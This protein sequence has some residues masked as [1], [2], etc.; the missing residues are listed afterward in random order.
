VN[1]LKRHWL[2]ASLVVV[3]I[4]VFAAF[5]FKGNEKPQ[6]FTTKVDRGEIREVVEAAGTINAVTTVQVVAGTQDH[7]WYEVGF[8]LAGVVLAC[9]GLKM[10]D[11]KRKQALLAILGV[12]LGVFAACGGGGSGGD[13]GAAHPGTPPGNYDHRQRHGGLGHTQCAGGS[14]GA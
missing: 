14:D 13:G 2:I 6:Y 8:S 10:P 3:A 7:L 12:V 5:Q 9:V 11:R 1:L 4:T